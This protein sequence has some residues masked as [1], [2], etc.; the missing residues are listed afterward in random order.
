MPF[1]YWDGPDPCWT[2]TA[3]PAVVRIL[4]A[5]CWESP[6]TDGTGTAPPETVIVTVEPGEAVPPLG[7]W[8]ITVPD[9]CV[10]V[11]SGL[12]ETWKPLDWSSVWCRRNEVSRAQPHVLPVCPQREEH[13][14]RAASLPVRLARPVATPLA[15]T[16]E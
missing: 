3:N 2:L 7:L 13:G 8:L 5:V 6:T 9:G 14:R 10:E 16:R 12:T 4:L 11:W 15:L 1:A